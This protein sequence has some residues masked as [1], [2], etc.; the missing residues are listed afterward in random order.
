MIR[1]TRFV[2]SGPSGGP[3]GISAPMPYRYYALINTSPLTIDAYEGTATYDD[4]TGMPFSQDTYFTVPTAATET[5]LTVFW[6]GGTVG[7]TYPI[8]LIVSDEPFSLGPGNVGITNVNVQGGTISATISG[9]TVSLA[10]GTSVGINGTVTVQGTVNIGTA[11]TITVQIS[12]TGNTVALAGGT[13][14]GIAGNVTVQGTVNIGTAPTLSVSI[15]GSGNTVNLAAGTVVNIGGT[16]TVQWTSTGPVS[17]KDLVLNSTDMALLSV[18]QVPVTIGVGGT[19][20]ISGDTNN[21]GWYPLSQAGYY[22]G[23][24]I[25]LLSQNFLVGT[26]PYEIAN[27]DTFITAATYGHLSA[28]AVTTPNGN[29]VSGWAATF[30]VSPQT[31]GGQNPPTSGVFYV[32][33]VKPFCAAFANVTVRATANVVGDTV[34]AWIFGLKAQTLNPQNSPAQIQAASGS[35]DTLQGTN[36]GN[37][38]TGSSVESITLIS[39]G[40]Y[41]KSLTF[42]GGTF[43]ASASTGTPSIKVTLFN[44]SQALQSWSGVTS[45]SQLIVPQTP[46]DFGGGVINSGIVLQVIATSTGTGPYVSTFVY[47]PT[48]GIFTYA[49]PPQKVSVVS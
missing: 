12:G 33:A 35:F 31:I 43:S 36:G 11:P 22:D 26:Y 21:T 10:A 32:L 46:F 13:Q 18:A 37:G 5:V 2:L 25:L 19:F 49:T 30:P 15:S 45:G 41:I 44:G 3:Y 28:Y 4:G 14:V 38:G 48:T 42:G 29:A 9:G 27:V 34:T 24:F 17:I 8:K 20:V 7:T 40:N 1:T 47:N 23:L 6:S 16:A 39:S